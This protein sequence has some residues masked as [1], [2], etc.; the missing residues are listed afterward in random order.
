MSDSV[1]EGNKEKITVWRGRERERKR[2][3]EQQKKENIKVKPAS[4]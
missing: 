1:D 2:S 4:S 3:K